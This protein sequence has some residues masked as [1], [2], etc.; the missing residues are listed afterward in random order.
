[1]FKNYQYFLWLYHTS[2]FRY[3][4]EGAQTVGFERASVKQRLLDTVHL[5]SEFVNEGRD[6]A[7]RITLLRDTR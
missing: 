5:V 7:S 6:A 2:E 1:M 3:F 4:R